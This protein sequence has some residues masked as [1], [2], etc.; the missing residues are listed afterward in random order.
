MSSDQASFAEAELRLAALDYAQ[1][2]VPEAHTR[3]DALLVRAPNYSA[4]LI[5]KAQWLTKENKLDEALKRAKAAVVADPQSA[6]AH[7]ALAV[8]QDRRRETADAINRMERCYASTH[9]R[10][11]RRWRYRG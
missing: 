3:L 2:R 10:S 11:P 5:V 7:F 6:P 9:E 4:A 1:N 8:V